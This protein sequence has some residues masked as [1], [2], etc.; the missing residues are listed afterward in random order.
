MQNRP[1]MMMKVGEKPRE[2]DITEAQREEGILEGEEE[3][4]YVEYLENSLDFGFRASSVLEPAPCPLG[5]KLL[6]FIF[7][8]HNSRPCCPCPQGFTCIAASMETCLLPTPHSN[9]CCSSRSQPRLLLLQNWLRVPSSC[10]Q[11]TL[12]SPCPSHLGLP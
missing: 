11:R 10:L 7:L 2:C 3:L 1:R 4:S 8:F 12:N 9:S 5:S 6:T